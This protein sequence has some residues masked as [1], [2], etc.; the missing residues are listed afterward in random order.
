MESTEEPSCAAAMLTTSMAMI[1]FINKV[2]SNLNFK[3]FSPFAIGKPVRA[4]NVEIPKYK[5]PKIQQR[6]Y[7]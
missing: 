6:G 2:M 5:S 7:L 3:I 4:D 1:N